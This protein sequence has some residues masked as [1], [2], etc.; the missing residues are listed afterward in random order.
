MALLFLLL[1][2]FQLKH[3][4]ADYPLQTGYMLGKFKRT[5][6]LAPLLAHSLV[7]ASLTF[8]I[9]WALV[10]WPWA[11]GL[12]MLD[13]GIHFT[14]DRLKASPNLLGRYKVL[15]AKELAVAAE[16]Q[17][18]GDKYTWW[19]ERKRENKYFWWTLGFDQMVHHLTHYAI[20]LALMGLK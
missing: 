5:G 10:A 13:L 17:K 20:I 12:S 15:S 19:E 14:M 9:C 1:I 8:L 11:L 16:D 6:Y 18:R 7:H 2:S 4:L 3:F